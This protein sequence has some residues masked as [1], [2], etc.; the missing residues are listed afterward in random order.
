MVIFLCEDRSKFKFTASLHRF[1]QETGEAI[2]IMLCFFYSPTPTLKT[3]T[4][5]FNLFLKWNNL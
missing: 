1:C 4:E 3:L 5:N 2:H